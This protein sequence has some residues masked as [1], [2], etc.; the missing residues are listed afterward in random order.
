MIEPVAS[1]WLGEIAPCIRKMS[2]IT[3]QKR[4]LVLG[5]LSAGAVMPLIAKA[6]LPPWL[7]PNCGHRTG[8]AEAE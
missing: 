6:A 3:P 7:L 8:A 1:P 4:I 2:G 5:Q